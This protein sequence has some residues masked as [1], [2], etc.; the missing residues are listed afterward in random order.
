MPRDCPMYGGFFPNEG[1]LNLG[2]LELGEI[3]R[4][5]CVLHHELPYIT[6][7]P[8]IPSFGTDADRHVDV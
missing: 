5:L 3:R 7:A 6:Y 1:S 4:L 8:M 2:V